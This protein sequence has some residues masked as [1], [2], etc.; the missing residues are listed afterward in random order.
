MKFLFPKLTY[1]SMF[2]PWI[3]SKLV[4]KIVFLNSTSIIIPNI[5]HFTC[6]FLVLYV[7]L[8]T[9]D[10]R[11]QRAATSEARKLTIQWTYVKMKV[12]TE[13][14]S[15]SFSKIQNQKMS[16][17]MSIFEVLTEP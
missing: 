6:S 3:T 13:L 5:P 1:K 9:T 12:I 16:L 4:I 11:A 7:W 10:W 2:R 14:V 8:H 15:D 17:K